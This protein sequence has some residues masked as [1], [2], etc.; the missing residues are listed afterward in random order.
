M[1][2]SPVELP[3]VGPVACHECWQC[4]ENRINDCVGRNIAEARVSVWSRYVTLTYGRVDGNADHPHAVVL[5]YS[6]VQKWIKLLRFHGHKVRYFVTGEFGSTFHRSHWHVLLYG[7][8][9]S[10]PEHPLRVKKF[11]GAHWDHGFSF[12]DEVNFKS[13][14][15][16]CK[17]ITKDIGEE[18]RQGHLGMSKKPPIGWR[19]FEQLAD[20]HARQM[21]APR[22]FFY[23]FSD[24]RDGRTG[25][26]EEFMMQGR[27][28]ELFLD[29]FVF[30]WRELHGSRPLPGSQILE[31]H[32][33]R[34]AWRKRLDDGSSSLSRW[35]LPDT[36]KPPRERCYS[37]MPMR[38]ITWDPRL[39]VWT[40]P[41]P[42]GAGRWYWR[43]GAAG[44]YR[45]RKG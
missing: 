15:Y 11:E 34:G 22:D 29:R 16:A 44:A 6:D 30:M 37:W 12:W 10:M 43:R 18:E 21:I 28:R 19:W 45:W 20:E 23:R 39:G 8:S 32:L 5:F 33:D 7:Q 27:T 38:A 14:R 31:E 35:A 40:A 4:V 13:V 24:V 25:K 26:P 36:P 3:G 1:C 2:V 9:D 41:A 17:Y 42:N